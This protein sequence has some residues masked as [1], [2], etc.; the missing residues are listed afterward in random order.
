[1]RKD[2]PQWARLRKRLWPDCSV[3]NSEQ[4]ITK[5]L[6]QPERYETFVAAD[7]NRLVGFL[8][9]SLRNYAPKCK[10]SPVGFIEGWYVEP[11][12]RRVGIGRALEEA[13]ER[14]AIDKGC[15]EMASDALIRNTRSHR[16]HRAHRALGY[17]EVERQV[18]FR[19]SL[20]ARKEESLRKQ[21]GG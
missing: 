9:A 10:T 18:C 2:M 20:P 13:A 11:R 15:R 19:K 12:Y 8:E 4:D 5:F 1:M 7:G 14:W 6:A 3:V 16:A 21:A 17:E